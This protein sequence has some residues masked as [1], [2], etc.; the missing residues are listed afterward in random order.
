[1][2]D[3]N[4]YLWINMHRRLIQ[5]PVL[6]VGSKFY[7]DESFNDF[8]RLCSDLNLEYFGVDLNEG[9]NVDM[10]IDL[11]QDGALVRNQLSR[12]F[13]TVICCSV[14][15]HV[16]D[17]FTFSGNL[18][19]LLEKGGTL[20][21]SVPFTW[22]NHGYPNDYWRFTPAAIEYLFSDLDFPL[23]Y[24]TISSHIPNDLKA[25]NDN[26]NDFCFKTLLNGIPNAN[27]INDKEGLLRAIYNLIFKSRFKNDKMLVKAIGTTRFFK[28]SC[29]NMI[30]I[31]KG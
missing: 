8:R 12:K 16:K 26:P 18:S 4:Q 20:F 10:V 6:E 2:G 22:E 11:A 24:R 19:D 29:I 23:K 21:L 31:K 27:S 3:I 17:I 7:S 30:G 25:M 9:K 1:M 13:K 14:M 28:P 5:A 15:E